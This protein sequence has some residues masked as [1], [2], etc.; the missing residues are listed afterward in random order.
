[1]DASYRPVCSVTADRRMGVMRLRKA[2]SGAAALV[3]LTM[4]ALLALLALPARAQEAAF[5]SAVVAVD[6]QACA[7]LGERRVRSPASPVRCDQLAIVRF[8]YT[9]FD[10]R[11]HR[12][13]EI[14]V[15]AAAAQQVRRLFSGLHARRFPIEGARLMDAYGGDDAA[16]MRDNNTSAFNDRPIT[17]GGPPSLHAY[18]LAIDLNP[19]QNPYVAFGQDGRATFEPSAGNRYANRREPR[20]GK[21]LRRGMAESTVR[22][23]AEHGFTVWGGDWD[24][25]IDYQHFQVRRD[26]AEKLAALPAEP[27][28]QHYERYAGLLRSCLRREAHREWSA[29]LQHCTDLAVHQTR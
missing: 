19:V 24:A 9:G 23:F 27:A 29:A 18:G 3:V 21:P 4:S 13:G 26:I 7:L 28:R 10:G 15:M 25:P 11:T 16:S 12:D 1:M 8:T 6:A 17:G 5:E 20:P 14:M 22:L 2:E